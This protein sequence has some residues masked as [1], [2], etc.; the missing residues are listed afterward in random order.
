MT[1][2]APTRKPNGDPQAILSFQLP[3]DE[4]ARAEELAR[5]LDTNISTAARIIFRRGL[6]SDKRITF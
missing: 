6:E 4:K 5:R 3:A 1:T 2:R